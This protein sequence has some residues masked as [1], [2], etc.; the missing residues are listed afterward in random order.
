MPKRRV[1]RTCDYL[2]GEVEWKGEMI[3]C[4]FKKPIH[5][6]SNDEIKLKI[7]IKNA[8]ELFKRDY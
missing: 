2:K 8:Q 5:I 7:N 4:R 1:V 6:E 3:N